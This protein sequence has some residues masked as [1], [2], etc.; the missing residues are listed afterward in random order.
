[1]SKRGRPKKKVEDSLKLVS[2]K[3]AKLKSKVLANNTEYSI[4]S[5]SFSD[6]AAKDEAMEHKR[7]K[8][9]YKMGIRD[10]D[11]S[12]EPLDSYGLSGAEYNDA[13]FD[14]SDCCTQCGGILK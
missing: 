10:S 13:D 5:M 11:D 7:A 1:V 14:D 4:K 6:S 9:D 3:V 8:N 2:Q 12:M